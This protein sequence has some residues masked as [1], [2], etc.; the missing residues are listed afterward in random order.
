VKLKR[1]PDFLPG[2]QF[3]IRFEVHA[4]VNGS[5]AFNGG[6]PDERFTATIAKEGGAAKSIAE[7]FKLTEPALQKWNFTWFE[8]LFA[9]DAKNATRVNVASK[10][11]RRVALYEPGKY[12]VTLNYYNGSKTTA[13]NWTVRPLAE[14]KKAKNVIFFIGTFL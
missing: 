8:D 2:Q 13:A 12:T 10:I 6:V 3:D 14:T 5:E 1:A 4:P 9:Q 7:Y 11:Y